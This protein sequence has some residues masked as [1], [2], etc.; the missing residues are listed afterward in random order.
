MS[1]HKRS[2]TGITAAR[3]ENEACAKIAEAVAKYCENSVE[4]GD[5][6]CKHSAEQLRLIVDTIRSRVPRWT[7]S[8]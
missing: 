2:L 1:G 3:A 8:F 5:V 6:T 7:D 4:E